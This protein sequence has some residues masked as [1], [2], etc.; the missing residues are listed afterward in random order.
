MDYRA[1]MKQLRDTLNENA[2][3]YY[4]LDRSTMSD[5]DYDYLY[6]RL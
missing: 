3:L 2:R 6:C 5:Y 1:E 4:T